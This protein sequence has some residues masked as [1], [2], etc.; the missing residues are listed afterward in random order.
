ME[1]SLAELLSHGHMAMGTG[2]YGGL[3][4][5]E[6]LANPEDYEEFILTTSLVS[7]GAH[8]LHW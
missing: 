6:L 5:S 8:V 3:L 1:A 4:E 2:L 7:L